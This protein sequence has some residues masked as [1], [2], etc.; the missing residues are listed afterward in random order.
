[1]VLKYRMTCSDKTF[2][3]Y[4]IAQTIDQIAIMLNT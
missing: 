2:V 1:M 3:K 4:D